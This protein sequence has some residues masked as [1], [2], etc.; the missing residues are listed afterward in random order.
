M[1]V[2][3]AVEVDA[4]VAYNDWPNELGVS[5]LVSAWP[6]LSQTHAWV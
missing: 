2:L 5:L 4:K 3:P 6:P 1:T